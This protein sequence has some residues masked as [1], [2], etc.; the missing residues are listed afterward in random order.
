MISAV[1]CFSR[2]LEMPY[3]RR[4][5]SRI[6]VSSLISSNERDERGISSLSNIIHNQKYSTKPSNT[7]L[8]QAIQITNTS[9]FYPHYPDNYQKIITNS[10]ATLIFTHKT[11]EIQNQYQN[12]TTPSKPMKK[13]QWHRRRGI[14]RQRP[15]LINTPASIRLTTLP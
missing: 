2:G 15:P 9:N 10:H 1:V 11:P 8:L 6:S 7:L 3:P 4:W 14:D 12:T 13:L 5:S